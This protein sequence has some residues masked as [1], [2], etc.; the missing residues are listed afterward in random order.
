MLHDYI[1]FK[2][3][4]ICNKLSD[5]FLYLLR[6]LREKNCDR[7]TS[8]KSNDINCNQSCFYN[9]I[10]T[11]L[12]G[13]SKHY[14]KMQSKMHIGCLYDKN[15]CMNT[16]NMWFEY[17]STFQW[18]EVF[19]NCT[20]IMKCTRL[21]FFTRLEWLEWFIHFV[22]GDASKD[23]HNEIGSEK[24]WWFIMSAKLRFNESCSLFT[25]LHTKHRV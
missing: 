13:L 3:P 18:C 16:F 1:H 25:T 23:H 20:V 15:A 14:K 8:T 12:T 2:K 24:N 19:C 7:A 9:T 11:T 4:A 17:A 22:C 10:K 5:L 21:F 6:E